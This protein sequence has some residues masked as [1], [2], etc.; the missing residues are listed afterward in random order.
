MRLLIL[1]NLAVSRLHSGGLWGATSFSPL[2]H[3][4]PSLL[5]HRA[6][7]GCSGL[8][9]VALGCFWAVL[10]F[11]HSLAP[12]APCA[13]SLPLSLSLFLYLVRNRKAGIWIKPGFGCLLIWILA[14]RLLGAGS[15]RRW[16]QPVAGAVL[17]AGVGDWVQ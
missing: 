8:I 3:R 2:L 5:S 9:W 7:L 13:P 17:M 6:M 10:I 4:E 16:A 1:A 15:W 11:S 14:L 12:F